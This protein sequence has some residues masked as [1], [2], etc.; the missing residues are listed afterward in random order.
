MLLD[1]EGK[2]RAACRDLTHA[3]RHQRRAHMD[4]GTL[5]LFML[6]S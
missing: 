2:K 4:K 6:Y 5:L 3:E 1:A